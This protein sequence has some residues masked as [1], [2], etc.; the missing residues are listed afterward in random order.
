MESVYIPHATYLPQ[1]EDGPSPY[2]RPTAVY[3]GN[4]FALWDHDVIF[5]AAKLLADQGKKPPI[6]F[7]GS[8]PDM[9]KWQAFVREN[10]LDNVRFTG[11][12]TGEA[13][14]RGLRHAHVLLC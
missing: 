6:V 1:F 9:E 2:D 14:W 4:F 7:M 5:R 11:Q 3:M 12:M 10:N 13:L 8:G